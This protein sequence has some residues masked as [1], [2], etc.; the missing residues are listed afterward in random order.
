MA[1]KLGSKVRDTITGFEGIAMGR[2]Q[3]IYGC[4]QIMVTPDRLGEGGK[5][6]EPEW[7]DE[8]RIETLEEREILISSESEAT[9]GGPQPVPSRRL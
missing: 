3:Y 2:T 5:R 6:L 7:F 8:Q 4:N 1:V 9:A